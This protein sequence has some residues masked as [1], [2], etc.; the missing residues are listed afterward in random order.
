MDEPTGAI[1]AAVD[2]VQSAW[3]R[4]MG[5]APMARDL[6]DDIDAMS[7]AGLVA[8]NEALAGV[9]RSVDALHTRIA[10]GI[11]ARSAPE[12]GKDGLARKNGFRTATKLI[13]ASTG[14]H[15]GDAR[16][17]IKVGQA[18]TPR[19]SFSG[20]RAPAAHPHVAQ[21]LASGL[22]SVAA[23]SAITTMLDRVAVAAGLAACQEAEETLVV[24][25][26]SLTLDEL[27]AVLQRAEAYLDPD[28]LEPKIDDLRSARV[29]HVREDRDGAI[30]LSGRLDPVTG[31]PIKAAIDAFVTAQLRSSRGRNRPPH[32]D[33]AEPATAETL[34]SA[35]GTPA[36]GDETRSIP[37]LKADALSAICRHLLG[38]DSATPTLP[39]TTVIVRMSLDALTTG[40]GTATIDGIAQPIDAGAARRMAA[41][42]EVIPCVLGADS[43]ILDFG[44]ARRLFTPAQK[45][46]LVERDGGC[47]ACGLP[48][49]FTEGHHIL[50]WDLH[51][52]D[53]DLRNGILLCAGCHHR[54]HTDGWEIRIEP[55]PSGDVTGGTVWFVP[56]AHIDADRRPRLGGRKR[57]DYALAV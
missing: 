54:I 47:A 56:P 15:G 22:L 48:P 7:D 33:V 43:E 14:S 30:V 21:A 16:R 35:D 57:F 51:R 13:A 27:N 10:A 4:A 34:E 32:D 50:W 38:C 19:M 45:L 55:P 53:T 25:A 26:Q 46:A 28:G 5:G 9:K 29:L 31:A 52:G 24:Q 12:L 39:T 2:A 1:E 11:A 8:V 23:A 41:D 3:S 36:L 40:I 42:A 44:Q 6:Q 37:Q 17:L 49:Q 20:E 18:T